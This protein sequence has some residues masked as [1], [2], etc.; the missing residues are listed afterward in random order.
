MYS[1][2]RSSSFCSTSTLAVIACL[3][4]MQQAVSAIP[5]RVQTNQN[6]TG[7]LPFFDHVI[8][9][10]MENTGRPNITGNKDMPF[11]NKLINE[12]MYADHYHGYTNPS[13]PNYIAITAGSQFWSF[14]DNPAQEFPHTNIADLLEE[15]GMTWKNYA[16]SIPTV[17]FLG[18]YYP[19]NSDFAVYV[20]RHVP[21]ALYPQ[22]TNNASRVKN[23]VPYEHILEDLKNNAL[24]NFSFITPDVCHDMHGQYSLHVEYDASPQEGGPNDKYCPFNDYHFM[25]TNGDKFVEDAVTNITSSD[26]WKNSN[27][28]IFITWDQSEVDFNKS[29]DGWQFVTAGPD[30][31]DLPAGTVLLPAGGVYG[32]GPV[33]L[34]AMWSKKPKN[35]VVYS[36]KSNHLFTLKTILK[37]WKLPYLAYTTDEMQ[38]KTF[39]SFFQ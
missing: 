27:S 25:W 5:V 36:E 29:T 6:S 31:P 39:D 30:S 1:R 35:H 9:I 38:I 8:I 19:N 7:S 10:M 33:P 28:V 20:K 17:G 3:C 11:I 13:L 26:Q 15:R 34:I 14:S 18:H 37:A 23:I 24:P 16:Q 2:N 21:F 32:G 12:E 4:L 22:I